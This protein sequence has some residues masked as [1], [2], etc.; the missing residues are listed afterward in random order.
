LRTLN[1][2]PAAVPTRCQVHC[3]IVLDLFLLRIVVG[4]DKIQ[5]I[6]E[7]LALQRCFTHLRPLRR[8]STVS[9]SPIVNARRVITYY[10]I[11]IRGVFE[12]FADIQEKEAVSFDWLA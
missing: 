1:R 3:K 7:S 4:A 6:A 5:M 11:L 10:P 2:V 9:D 12:R 8:L